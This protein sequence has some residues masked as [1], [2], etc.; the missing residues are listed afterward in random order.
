MRFR[1]GGGVGGGGGSFKGEWGLEGCQGSRGES[2]ENMASPSHCYKG[3]GLCHLSWLIFSAKQATFRKL[4]RIRDNKQS[5]QPIR[6]TD[7]SALG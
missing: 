4:N 7:T 6:S 3:R 5:R 1:K 2:T